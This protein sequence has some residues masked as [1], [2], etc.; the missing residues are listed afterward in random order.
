MGPKDRTS[1]LPVPAGPAPCPLPKA[2]HPQVPADHPDPRILLV[3]GPR[4]EENFLH[5]GFL[6]CLGPQGTLVFLDSCIAESGRAEQ[7]GLAR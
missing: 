3:G 6:A 4:E 7:T 1:G 2:A 5:E